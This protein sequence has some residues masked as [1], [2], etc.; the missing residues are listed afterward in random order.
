MSPAPGHRPPPAHLI[1]IGIPGSPSAPVTSAPAQ[2]ATA[3]STRAAMTGRTY[4]NPVRAP[5]SGHAG[6]PKSTS[7]VRP[8]GL[9]SP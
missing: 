5:S 6:S 8:A 9:E 1:P 2:S 4:R 3:C 7:P